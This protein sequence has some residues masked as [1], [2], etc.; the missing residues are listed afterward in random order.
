MIDGP[1]IEKVTTRLAQQ[2]AQPG[3]RTLVDVER[4]ARERLVRHKGEV[5]AGI[6]AAIVELEGLCAARPDGAAAEVYRLASRVLD[7]AG[8][9]D[10]GPLFEA[11]YS[12]ADVAD[13][14]AVADA[15]DWPSV[16]V[17]VQALRLILNGGCER[18]AATDR[19]LA[20]L[21]AVAV[22]TRT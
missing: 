4:R 17:H 2:M 1:K 11:G 5:M 13:R 7:L 21:K 12:L 14:M 22:K 15:W 16:E 18:N 8:F 20:G 9:F 10:T 19:M 3:G 6:D